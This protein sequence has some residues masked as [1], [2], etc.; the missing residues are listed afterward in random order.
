MDDGFKKP[1]D[2]LVKEEEEAEDVEKATNG[3]NVDNKKDELTRV[4]T[5]DPTPE[6]PF[7]K[8]RTVAMV[9]TVAG[10]PFLS[11]SLSCLC[12]RLD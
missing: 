3:Q 1:D 6:L 4:E 8:A 5:M 12:S 7:S 2:V 10:A 9:A 11:V